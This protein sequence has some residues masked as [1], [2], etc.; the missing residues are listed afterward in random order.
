MGSGGDG[1][2]G[3][4][5]GLQGLRAEQVRGWTWRK[6]GGWWHSQENPSKSPLLICPN[7]RTL[8]QTPRGGH[9]Y[10]SHL[11]DGNHEASG[12]LDKPRE[13]GLASWGQLHRTGRENSLAGRPGRPCS[14]LGRDPV[15]RWEKVRPP[16]PTGLCPGG[17]GRGCVSGGHP[18]R[19]RGARGGGGRPCPRP[20][21]PH[22]K[23][24]PGSTIVASGTVK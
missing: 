1:Q 3:I 10:H 19:V 14:P 8:R 23:L 15:R 7:R 12:R 4:R 21:S 20:A 17:P 22:H 24:H 11:T 18:A 5:P 2:A 13:K 9:P 6:I 16:Q